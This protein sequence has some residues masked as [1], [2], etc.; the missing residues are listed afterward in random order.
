M[1][2]P[3]IVETHSG[4]A[5]PPSYAPE[6]LRQGVGAARWISYH[7]EQESEISH[8]SEGLDSALAMLR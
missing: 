8:A 6:G 2:V 3:E 1:S 7:F 4:K 5:N